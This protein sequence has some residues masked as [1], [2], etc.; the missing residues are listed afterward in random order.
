MQPDDAGAVLPLLRRQVLRRWRKPLVVMTP[1]SL[2]RHPQAVSTLDELRARTL[3]A[4]DP[5][6]ARRD[7]AR[8]QR[9]LLCTGKIYY[10]LEKRR[11]EL[12]RDDVAIVRVE[13][14][15]PLPD[16]LLAAR[17]R[18]LSRRHAGRLGA[19]RAGEHG[20]LALP[21]GAL[22]RRCC[23]DASR[24]RGVCRAGRRSPATGSAQQPQA[25]TA[26]AAW[27]RAFGMSR[28]TLRELV[29][30]IHTHR[31][32]TELAMAIEL[33]VPAVGESITEV[34]IGEWLKARRRPRRATTR[35][36]S[37]SRPTRPRSSSPAP[38]ERRA[39]RSRSEAE[40]ETAASA[41]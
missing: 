2:L 3:P 19:G 29:P 25:R 15:Y 33:K 39:R 26:R 37:R 27:Q 28:Q 9:V 4:R 31:S 40:G 8:S 12:G 17:A 13:Q 10:D 11:A 34:Q 24:C 21:A 18:A 14:L 30:A 41:K 36:S 6:R 5:G 32:R 23:S 7:R 38:V 22:R 35:T 16:E 20:R 1:K